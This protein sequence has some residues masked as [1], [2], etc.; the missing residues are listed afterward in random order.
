MF[1]QASFTVSFT[2]YIDLLFPKCTDAAIFS[3]DGNIWASSSGWCFSEADARALA[4]I[5]DSQVSD[6]KFKGRKYL[7]VDRTVS[8]VIGRNKE[9]CMCI[10]KVKVYYVAS[11]SDGSVRPR[12]N[13]INL[14][15]VARM[16][17]RFQ[18]K[19][20]V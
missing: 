6:F 4:E 12:D 5:L 14:N 3:S 13:W 1:S 20:S 9:F 11:F 19:T 16:M 7:T 10:V 18:T 8:S 17:N 2:D 15:R